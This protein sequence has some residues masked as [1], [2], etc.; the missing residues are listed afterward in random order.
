MKC[1]LPMLAVLILLGCAHLPHEPV[2]NPGDNAQSYLYM[3]D[4]KPLYAYIFMNGDNCT[5][6]LKIN[7]N[8]AF[9]LIESG[10]KIAISTAVQI[11]KEGIIPSYGL[12]EPTFS[13]T[14]KADVVYGLFVVP[15]D[16]GCRV[17][18]YSG[19]KTGDTKP[20]KDVKFR[21]WR[22]AWDQKENG[23]CEPLSK[24]EQKEDTAD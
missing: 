14:P 16:G 5:H 15:S 21:K 17:A 7:T 2:Y 23:F 1:W 11:K 13:F 10:H 4:E 20:V 12:C 24:D 19:L 6:R 18:L 22:T 9:M 3:G 8:E